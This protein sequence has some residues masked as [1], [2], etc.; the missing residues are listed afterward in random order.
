M[1]SK[2]A[3]SILV[4]LVVVAGL[5]GIS[6]TATATFPGRNGRIAFTE[7]GNIFT[8]NPDGSDVRQ[9]TSF[10]P[11]AAVCCQAWSPD[12]LRLVF[13]VYP[14][15]FSSIQLWITNADGTSQHL[16][17]DDPAYFDTLASFSPDGAHVIFSHCIPATFQCGIFRVRA[18]GTD[19]TEILGV[20]PDPDVSDFDPVYAPDGT[21]IAFT[22]LTRG[23]LADVVYL[24][25]PDAS[26]IRSLTPP[27]L[28]AVTPDW[29]P[30]GSKIVFSTGFQYS[31][32]PPCLPN[33]ALWL[34]DPVD[35]DTTQLTG[36]TRHLDFHPSWSPQGDAITF[37]RDTPTGQTS[38]YLMNVS[39]GS[40]APTLI[41]EGFSP[42]RLG[43]PAPGPA[44]KRNRVRWRQLRAIQDG[45]AFPRW[46][47]AS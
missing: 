27:V 32:S 1:T 33:P 31:D 39:E 47:P 26:N 11:D 15:D 29:S 18:D 41:H 6:E 35:G 19:L 17:L 21:T 12:G 24:M 7:A 13:E 8:M 40:S 9:I 2:R 37:E 46:G 30:N 42:K 45:G 43:P 16:L 10:G 23:G 20:D 44:S 3:S 14:P 25:N 34:V 22:G 28:G 38:I 36:S 4:W 5:I